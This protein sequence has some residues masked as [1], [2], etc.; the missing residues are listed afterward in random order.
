MLNRPAVLAFLRKNGATGLVEIL[1]NFAAPY[2][3][4]LEAK[5][6]LGV[7][8]ALIASSA[9]PVLWSIVEFVRKRRMDALSII[10]LAGIALSLLAF[11]GGGSVRYLQLRENL[12][13]V[14]IGLVFLGSAA[15]GRPLVYQLARAS[16]RRKSQSEL[17]SFDALRDNR[18]FRRTMTIMTLVWGFGLLGAAAISCALLFVVSIGAYLLISP[19]VSYGAM[20]CLGLWTF[21]YGNLQRR[22]GNARRAA[23]ATFGHRGAL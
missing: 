6:G 17:A 11:L 23:L 14:L 20:G 10:V 22:K 3:I 19:A 15:I 21:Y 13:T 1:V 12:V 18:Y 2:V 5:H 8:N 16:L 9:P 4:Y 7:V